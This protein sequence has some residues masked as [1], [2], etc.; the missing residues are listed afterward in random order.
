MHYNIPQKMLLNKINRLNAQIVKLKQTQSWRKKAELALRASEEKYRKLIESS[1]DAIF[2]VNAKNGVIFDAN[3]RAEELLG[4]PRNNIIGMNQTEL[5]PKEDKIRYRN[6]FLHAVRQKKITITGEEIL[7]CHKNGS[8]IPVSV[9]TSTIKA[10]KKTI[11]Q[12]VFRDMTAQK[13]L[14]HEKEILIE[15]LKKTTNELA[16]L[17]KELESK[18]AQSAYELSVTHSRLVKIEK[19]HVFVR[20]AETLSHELRN[21][22]A[23]INNIVYLLSI[24]GTNIQKEKH[25]EYLSILRKQINYANRIISDAMDFTKP[26]NLQFKKS[27]LTNIIDNVLEE[28]KIAKNINVKKTYKDSIQTIFDSYYMHRMF[29]NIIT[30][31]IQAIQNKGTIEIYTEKKADFAK[32][33]IS[34]TGSGIRKEDIP[35]LFEPLFSRKAGHVGLGLSLVRNIVEQ[36]KGTIEIESQPNKGTDVIIKLPAK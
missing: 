12:I 19:M 34:D 33:V 15:N 22:L 8:R 18:V 23:I 5:H 3:K 1:N 4:M 28:I 21:P 30:N 17:N 7:L 26:K 27:S 35:L 6:L 20:L 16:V 29:F 24:N 25:H 2:L 11:V 32:I 10:D 14:E 36:H 31:C 13:K 9:S